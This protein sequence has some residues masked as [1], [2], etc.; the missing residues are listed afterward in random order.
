[1]K[2][3]AV[4]NELRGGTKDACARDIIILKHL[5]ADNDAAAERFDVTEGR[6]P[7]APT[8]HGDDVYVGKL[9]VVVS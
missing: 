8:R 6:T 3:R 5:L 2:S 1:M 9:L 4:K 7:T